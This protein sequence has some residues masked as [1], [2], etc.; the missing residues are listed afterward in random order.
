MASW[1]L[2]WIERKLRER[3]G[4]KRHSPP[5]LEEKTAISCE[6]TGLINTSRIQMR[7][8]VNS[9]LKRQKIK[10][11]VNVNEILQVNSDWIVVLVASTTQKAEDCPPG[12]RFI[13]SLKRSP[14]CLLAFVGFSLSL[15]E[16]PASL[17][18]VQI[19]RGM[20]QA[21]LS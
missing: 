17:P 7:F 11:H 16:S 15:L 18:E 5:S 4:N 1:S 3:L 10:M 13:S 20:E 8:W 9:F 21:R 6:A 12:P 2:P 19:P 14:W